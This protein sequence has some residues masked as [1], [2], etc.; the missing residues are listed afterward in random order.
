MTMGIPVMMI[1]QS[2][3]SFRHELKH[4]I[5][6]AEDRILTDRL[7]RLFHRDSHAGPGGVYTV[8]S[9]YFDTPD[10]RALTEKISGAD[11]REKFRIRY[12]G[13]TP[14][15]LRLEKRLKKAGFAQNAAPVLLINRQKICWKGK[16]NFFWKAK[17][18]C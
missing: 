11:R 4:L 10:D 1:E 14:D 2:P 16:W 12:Y 8:N 5:T 13:D 17:T 15:F 7:G 18:D 3:V 9:L 6:P